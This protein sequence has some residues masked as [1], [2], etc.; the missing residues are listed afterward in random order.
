MKTAHT[1]TA[2]IGYKFLQLF[3]LTK[4]NEN[5][6]GSCYPDMSMCIENPT[7]AYLV[8]RRSSALI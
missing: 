4:A 7:V 3:S 5:L 6:C 8:T 2:K 1:K